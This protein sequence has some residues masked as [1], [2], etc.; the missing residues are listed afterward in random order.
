MT[1]QHN[2]GASE[3][4][5]LNSRSAWEMDRDHVLHPYADFTTFAATGSQVIEK[6]EGMFV[7]DSTGQRFLDGI[8]G[9]WC[10]NIG[11]GRREMADAIARQVLDMEYYNPFGASTNV[12]AAELAA[13]LAD[14]S[15]G[16]LN[17]VYYTCGGSTANDAAIRIVHYY[18]AMRGQPGKRKIISRN[19]AYHGA[20]YVAAGL[21]GIH[22][23]KYGFSQVGEDFIHHVS[24]ADCYAKPTDMTEDAYRDFLVAEFEM[25]IEQLGPQNVAAFIAEPIMGAGGVLVAPKG[26]H[27]AMQAVCRR[28]DILYIADEVV[29]AFGRLGEWFAS[30]RIYETQPDILVSAKGITSGYIPLGATL[31]SDEI[32]AVISRPQC[33]GGVFSMGLTYSGHPVA[34]AAALTNI[35]IMEREQLLAHAA[36]VGAYLQ[37]KARLL[38]KHDIVGDVRGGGLM[39]GIDFVADKVTRQPLPAHEKAT[40]KIFKGCGERGVIVRP[41][42]NRIILSPPLI[43]TESQCDEI[44]EA[45]SGSVADFMAAR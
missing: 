8:A 13:R 41:V 27:R 23:T 21:T 43:I 19:N 6:A 2:L 42:G 28:H 16:S 20:T 35:A 12:P 17:H 32:H 37:Q 3:R 10:V 7:T 1:I 44:L 33:E 9:L 45:I 26:Y 4:T 36:R 39:L 29:T 15:P 24:A 25:R 14:L 31:I 34:C 40:E 5:R 30:D 38:L 18:F 11:H 22:G